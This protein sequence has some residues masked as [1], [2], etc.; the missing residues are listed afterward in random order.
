MAVAGPIDVV[1]T[2]DGAPSGLADLAE[3]A[4]RAELHGEAVQ[5]I[6]VAKSEGLKQATWRAKDL[7]H[8]DRYYESRRD[9]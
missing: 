7:E 9:Q 5:I 3:H 2:P 8:L 6:T 1:F 4:I